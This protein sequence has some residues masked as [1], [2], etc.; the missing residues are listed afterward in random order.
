MLAHLYGTTQL[1]SCKE[2]ITKKKI[3]NQKYKKKRKKRKTVIKDTRSYIQRSTP[4]ELVIL[5]RSFAMASAFTD[6]T[7]AELDRGSAL[8]YLWIGSFLKSKSYLNDNK[9]LPLLSHSPLSMYLSLSFPSYT[10]G[11]RP[12]TRGIKM[13]LNRN[14]CGVGNHPL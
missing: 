9:S 7:N 1:I 4:E 14:C 10:F 12:S 5:E 13:Q 2:N 6:A 8:Y 11:K 3:K